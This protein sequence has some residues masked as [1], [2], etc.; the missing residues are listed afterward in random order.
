MLSHP[1][2][3]SQSRSL[4]ESCAERTV[5]MIA[6]LQRQLLGGNSAFLALSLAVE[7]NEVV[8]TQAIDVSII[9]LA[10]GGKIGT[11]IGAVGVYGLGQLR[12]RQVMLQVELRRFA[13]LSQ[14]GANQYV[15][16]VFCFF[17]LLYHQCLQRLHA[18]HHEN[19]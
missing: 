19:R 10:L 17:C 8:D 15:F 14:Q 18:P 13:V 2:C 6:A 5:A 9:R 3:N 12:K 16:L 1:G 11:Q 7:L 4:F